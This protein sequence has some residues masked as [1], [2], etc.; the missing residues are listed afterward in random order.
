MRHT[1]LH[2][3]ARRRSAIEALERGHSQAEVAA[4]F[5]TSVASVSQWKQKFMREGVPGLAAKP[6]G[7][8]R[9]EVTGSQL[10]STRACLLGRWPEQEGLGF[11]VWHGKLVAGLLARSGQKDVSRWTVQ[12]YLDAWGLLPPDL[13]AAPNVWL[14]Q[15][16]PQAASGRHVGIAAQIVQS[17][18]GPAKPGGATPVWVLWSRRPRGECGFLAY[19]QKP[20]QEQIEGFVERLLIHSPT[21]LLLAAPAGDPVWTEAALAA[22]ERRWAGQLTVV[23]VNSPKG[24]EPNATHSIAGEEHCHA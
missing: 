24:D 8:P 14:R 18:A 15:Y 19:E 13:S 17:R 22:C 10:E 11:G 3:E 2:L 6:Q 16:V 7:R 21:R 9:M 4:M 20:S 23:V 1:P 5:G 12:R